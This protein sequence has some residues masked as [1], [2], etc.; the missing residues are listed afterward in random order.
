MSLVEGGQEKLP[1]ILS[2]DDK[3]VSPPVTSSRFHVTPT[4]GN[5]FAMPLNGSTVIRLEIPSGTYASHLN[6]QE[7]ALAITV[8]NTSGQSVTI[9]TSGFSLIDA[10]DVYFGSTHL[11]SIS[12]YDLFCTI[13]ADFSGGNSYHHAKGMADIAYTSTVNVGS[14][15]NQTTMNNEINNA[16]SASIASL[17]GRN[18][19][20]IASGASDTFVLPVLNLIGSMA[21]KA[22]PIGELKDNLRIEIKTATALDA[23]VYAANPSSGLTI[24]SCKL[25]LT[26]INLDGASHAAL[27]KQLN[28]QY[29]VPFFD[30]ETFRTSLGPNVSAWSYTIPIKVASLTTIL[31]ALRENAVFN[32]HNQRSL[33][34]TKS[35]LSDY[36]FRIGSTTVPSAQID[37]TGSAAEARMELIRAFNQLNLPVSESYISNAIYNLGAATANAVGAYGGFCF[38]LNLSAMGA[39]DLLSDGRN[40]RLENLTVD[41]RFAGGNVAMQMDV[42]CIHEKTIL[43]EKG[44]IMYKN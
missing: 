28:G 37:C 2:Y 27:D 1:Q 23:G 32:A 42:F 10:I 12:Q 34:R 8:Q 19:R 16:I 39:A 13:M 7:T 36:R 11:S 9:D 20:T 25:W 30:V 24:S 18:G 6:T 41:I 15:F 3:F 5:T 14:A 26:T 40:V 22:I 43:C 17:N 21:M 31:V 38:A 29:Y 35:T 33:S 44:A 4:N